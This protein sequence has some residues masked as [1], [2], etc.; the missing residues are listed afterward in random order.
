MCST[1]ERVKGKPSIIVRGIT[2]YA[3]IDEV[4]IHSVPS[5]GGELFS[6]PR[7]VRQVVV[8]GQSQTFSFP[9]VLRTTRYSSK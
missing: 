7:G 4:P 9:C 2:R 3:R 6:H 8:V 5:C 1:A